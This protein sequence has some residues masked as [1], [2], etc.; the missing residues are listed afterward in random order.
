[1]VHETPTREGQTLAILNC[2]PAGYA[3]FSETTATD[4]QTSLAIQIRAATAA[5]PSSVTV[6]V[7]LGIPPVVGS[8]NGPPSTARTLIEALLRHRVIPRRP[9]IQMQVEAAP[10]RSRTR[11]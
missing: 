2:T 8:S 3:P 7:A 9:L 6:G 1:M 11:T 4:V 10:R 5:A